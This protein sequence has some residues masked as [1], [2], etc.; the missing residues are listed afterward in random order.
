MEN[1]KKYF[2]FG[3]T[4]SGLNYFLRQ[5]L[6]TTIAF[7]G[8]FTLGYG[9]GDNSIGLIT[10]GIAILS[11]A[12]WMSFATIYKR[13][14]ALFPGLAASYTLGIVILQLLNQFVDKTN[15]ILSGVSSIILF[16]IGLYL[17]FKNSDIVEHN[18]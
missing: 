1:L 7:I 16:G 14:E 10:L 2:E 11:P 15:S 8:G 9:I 13:C 5:L 18:G 4:I 3:G 6:T 17:I 12:V